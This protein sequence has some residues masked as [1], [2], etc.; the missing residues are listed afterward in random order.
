MAFWYLFDPERLHF[1]LETLGMT[2]C[3]RPL[4][5]MRASAVR[6][7]ATDAMD[8]LRPAEKQPGEPPRALP[9]A[10]AFPDETEG[11][12]RDDVAALRARVAA[13]EEELLLSKR[14]A[15]LMRARK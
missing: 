8:A 9:D 4:R 3:G 15:R 1:V 5:E 2:V 11:E 14:A 12:N 7:A 10:G 6:D 13:L